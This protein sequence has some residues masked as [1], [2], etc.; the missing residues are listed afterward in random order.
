MPG[1]RSFSKSLLTS[2]TLARVLKSPSHLGARLASVAR[3]SSSICHQ[4]RVPVLSIDA[5][6][7]AWLTELAGAG[8]L[9]RSQPHPHLL[10][11]QGQLASHSSPLS[12]PK[13][14]TLVPLIPHIHPF[15]S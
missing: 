9:S 15:P 2:P 11:D 14:L 13:T 6:R 3:S 4:G 10:L 8:P 5:Q 1:S 12:G 7:W